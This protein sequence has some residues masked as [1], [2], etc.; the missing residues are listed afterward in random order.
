MGG[1]AAEEDVGRHDP[2]VSREYLRR[3]QQLVSTIERL[4]SEPG[5]RTSVLAWKPQSY[6]EFCRLSDTG[7]PAIERRGQAR[8]DPIMR[9]SFEAIVAAFDKFAVDAVQLLARSSGQSAGNL[10]HDLEPSLRTMRA[11][12]DRAATLVEEGDTLAAEAAGR[13]ANRPYAR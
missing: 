6:Q 13:R 4:P 7:G 2:A 5:L 9:R 3:L 10:E 1:R 8:L 11:L 12:V